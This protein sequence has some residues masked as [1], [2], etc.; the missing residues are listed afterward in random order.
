MSAPTAQASGGLHPS[1]TKV[2][3]VMVACMLSAFVAILDMQIVATALPRI[4]GDLGGIDLFAWVTTAYVIASSVTTP[5]YG[6]LGDLFGRKVVYLSAMALFLLGS[7]LSGLAGSMELLIVFRIVQGLGA[8]GLFVSVL[9][10][11]GELFTPREGAKYYGMFGMVFAGASLAGP[12]VGGL[13][14]D[15]LSWHWVFLVNLP[16]GA[17]IVALLAKYLHLPRKVRESKLDYAGIVTLSG[18]IVAVTLLTSWG[19]VEYSW[20]SPQIIGLGLA[21][22]LLLGLFVKAESAAAEPIVPLRLFK[23]STFTIS[24][25]GTMI[26]GIVFVGT[27]NFLA[28]YVQV[29]TGASPTTSGFVLLPM[30]LGLVLTSVVSSK[31]IG[32]TGKY[33]IFPILSMALGI[34]GAVLL[35]TMDADTPR[36]LAIAYMLVFGLASGLSA[37]VFTQAAQNTAPPQDMG[38]V[39]GTVTFGRSFGTSIGIS[40]F[41]A[42]FYGRLTDEIAD[43]VPA[44]ALNGVDHNSLSSDTVLNSLDATVRTAIEQAYAAALTPVFIAAVPVLVV[45]LV[46][47][48]LM[49]N[50]TLRSRHHGGGGDGA[51]ADSA[52]KE[53]A[54]VTADSSP[55]TA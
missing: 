17:V 19:G 30:M 52:A 15:A 8:G 35:S 6:K 12:A 3:P 9:A 22:L 38:A 25:L 53:T 44:G 4:A 37:Q 48:L 13:L 54:P 24:L 2:T 32:K 5:I 16:V 46:L 26:C 27:V 41:A 7:A 14:T 36:A 45:G 55:E 42:I 1:G 40:L 11:I 33:K 39:S 34:V 29:A 47:T 31:I 18:A 20:T 51:P 28:L 23:D 21:T 49:K 50:S 43:R 10:I